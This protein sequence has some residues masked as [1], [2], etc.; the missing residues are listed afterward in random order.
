MTYRI[1]CRV[2]GGVTG[3]REAYYKQSG[4]I[5]ETQDR[6]Q[7]EAKARS[8]TETMNNPYSTATFRYTVL[9]VT[10]YDF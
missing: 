7:A 1:W 4:Q 6:E 2:S 10:Q 3:T 5:W 8:M 9:Q